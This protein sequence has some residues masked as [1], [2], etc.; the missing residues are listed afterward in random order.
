MLAFISDLHLTD[1]TSGT[2]VIPAVIDKFCRSLGDI[3]WK[4]AWSGSFGYG[5]QM[6]EKDLA[7][8]PIESYHVMTYINPYAKR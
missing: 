2:T 7:A 6:K 3:I 8:L 4:P 1:G 5:Q